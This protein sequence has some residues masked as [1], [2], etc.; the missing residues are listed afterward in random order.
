[1]ENKEHA[2]S[3]DKKEKEIREEEEA[4]SRSDL[5]KKENFGVGGEGEEELKRLSLQAKIHKAQYFNSV[6]L[7]F[8]LV[9][10]AALLLQGYFFFASLSDFAK[11]NTVKI[12]S[13][14][15]NIESA[16]KALEQSA[17]AVQQVSEAQNKLLVDPETQ[18]GIAVLL[19]QADDVARTVKKVNI[20]LDKVNSD[21]LPSANKTLV[22]TTNTINQAGATLV[23]TEKSIRILTAKGEIIL[24]SSN[25]S[26]IALQA[27]LGHPRMQSIVDNLANTTEQSTEVLRNLDISAKEVNR[28][29]P[30]L[31]ESVKSVANNTDLSGKEV[32]KFLQ[33]IN[34]PMSKKEKL[35]RLLLETIIKSSPVLLKR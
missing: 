15:S 29:I 5:R 18:K 10:I 1:M 28:A 23:Q 2:A 11:N 27:I 3:Q 6:I 8:I 33:G 19:R 24:D 7:G 34:K 35:G 22:A 20:I 13:T 17:K 4:L 31:L 9:I 25:T 21:I 14:I 30:E 32:T 12:S 16:S 26:I